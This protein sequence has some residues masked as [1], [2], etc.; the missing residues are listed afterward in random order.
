MK[1]TISA[2]SMIIAR[3]GIKRC[4]YDTL[5]VYLNSMFVHWDLVPEVAVTMSLA[6]SVALLYG[7]MSGKGLHS[8]VSALRL[9]VERAIKREATSN[10]RSIG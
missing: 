5:D 4:E 2:Q 7:E 9:G 1:Y 6:Y 10:E 8:C 3:L